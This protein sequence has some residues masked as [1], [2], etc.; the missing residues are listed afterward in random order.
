MRQDKLLELFDT[1]S[2][3]NPLPWLAFRHFDR[4]SNGIL[5]DSRDA[6]ETHAGWGFQTIPVAGQN[7]QPVGC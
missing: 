7:P 3:W 6:G 4:Q 2:R 1:Q 5:A